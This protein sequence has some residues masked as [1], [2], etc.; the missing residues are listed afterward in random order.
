MSWK[1][2]VKN[3]EDSFYRRLADE[4]IKDFLDMLEYEL[5]NAIDSIETEISE[6]EYKTSSLGNLDYKARKMI[7]DMVEISNLKTILSEV[8]EAIE[9][10]KKARESVE[11]FQ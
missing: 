3:E 7:K 5:T 2:I 8:E 1:D 10:L 11:G 4:E 9:A 6:F